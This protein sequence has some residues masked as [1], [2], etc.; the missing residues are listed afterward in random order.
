MSC[1]YNEDEIEKNYMRDAMWRASGRPDPY[2]SPS[3]LA[4]FIAPVLLL[5]FWAAVYLI[6]ADNLDKSGRV[7]EKPKSGVEDRIRNNE[8]KAPN[9]TSLSPNAAAQR[10]K[11][12]GLAG[13]EVLRNGCHGSVNRH[14]AYGRHV[15]PNL[16]RMG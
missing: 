16:P 3:H 9:K 2:D 13:N 7:I 15:M 5:S 11:E 14:I 12:I 8:T 1:D 4:F 6:T 10:A